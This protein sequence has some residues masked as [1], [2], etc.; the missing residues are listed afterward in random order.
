VFDTNLLISHLDIL[1]QAVEAGEWQIVIP[2][3]GISLEQLFNE[4]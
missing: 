1:K 4:K 2:L 3:I